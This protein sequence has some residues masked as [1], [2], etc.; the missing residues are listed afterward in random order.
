MLGGHSHIHSNATLSGCVA[1]HHFASVGSFSFVGG[2]SKV[3]QDIP[4]Y[5]LADGNPARCK[6][7]NIVALKRNSFSRESIVALN[8]TFRLLYRGRVGSE[9][10]REVL[11]SKNMLC[12]EVEQLLSFLSNSREGRHGRSRHITKAAA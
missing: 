2:V 8:E 3:M 6:C 11:R 10:A 1:V 4:P 12:E 9:N 7:T 5:M